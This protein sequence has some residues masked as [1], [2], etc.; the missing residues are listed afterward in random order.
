MQLVDSGNERILL[1]PVLLRRPELAGLVDKFLQG[2]LVGLHF[3]NVAGREGVVTQ[4]L[5]M[6]VRERLHRIGLYFTNRR[7][8]WNL[9]VLSRGLFSAGTCFFLVSVSLLWAVS[10]CLLALRRFASLTCR[11]GLSRFAPFSCGP[12]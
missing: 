5:L 9:F 6:A 2:S 3:L 7:N 10:A 11:A 8:V 1:V 12:A 4:K